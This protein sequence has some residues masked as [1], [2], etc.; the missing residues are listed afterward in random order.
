MGSKAKKLLKTILKFLIS[1]TALYIV[2]NNISWAAVEDTLRGANFFYLLLAT[3]F[4]VLSKVLSAFRLQEFFRC[5]E[6][7]I[8][9]K[10]NLRLYWIGMFYNLFLPGGIGGDGYKVYLLNKQYGIK[11]KPLIQASLIDRISGLVSLLV[12]VGIGFFFLE[13]TNFP[14]WLIYLDVACLLLVFPVLYL[15]ARVFFRPFTPA[16]AKSMA[17]SLAVQLS[18]V[19]SAAFILFGLGEGENPLAYMVLFLISSFVSIFPFT[20]GGIGSREIT[21]LI[22][23]QYLGIDETISVSLSLLFTLIS[24]I[25]SFGGIFMKAEKSYPDTSRTV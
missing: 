11:V 17:W 8:S 4:F 7:E 16:L 13:E 9:S 1:G 10:Y 25:V 20:I 2:F 5:I 15:L 6:L 12:L 3:L 22:G 14:A 21:F 19:V 18:Q 24:A 23:Y